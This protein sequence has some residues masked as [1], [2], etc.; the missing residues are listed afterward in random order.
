MGYALFS[1]Q[2]FEFS[3]LLLSFMTC[4]RMIVGDFDYQAMEDTDPQMAAF[5][6]L[7]FMILFTLILLNMF[8]A[9][10]GAHYSEYTEEEEAQN[11]SE[12][13]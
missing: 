5:F 11:N 10:I 13:D 12:T 8:I 7:S 6:F 9:I 1:V 3:T 4:F 2:L